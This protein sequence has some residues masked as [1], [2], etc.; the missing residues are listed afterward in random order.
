MSPADDFCFS[1]SFALLAAGLEDDKRR[2]DRLQ[3][4]AWALMVEA[5]WRAS[6]KPRRRRG[7]SK[8]LPLFY[9]LDHQIRLKFTPLENSPV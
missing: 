3:E 4:A 5:Y 6:R 7:R 9:P 1:I 2:A 8:Q